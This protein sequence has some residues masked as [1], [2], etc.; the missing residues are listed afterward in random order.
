MNSY[1][2]H[3]VFSQPFSVENLKFDVN[4]IA[5]F[6]YDLK[7]TMNVKVEKS[8][9]GGW[10]SS[11]VDMKSIK[12]IEFIKLLDEIRI[13]INRVSSNIGIFPELDI[14]NLWININQYGNYN[15][16]HQHFGS[17]LSGTF[18]VRTPENCGNINFNNPMGPLMKSYIHPWNF[19][20]NEL[21]DFPWFT[22]GVVFPCKE[23]MMLIFPSWMEHSVDRNS[24]IN[25]DRISISFNTRRK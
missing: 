22:S 8:N 20:E 11:D 13:G 14:S 4:K 1:K 10:Q 18:Y 15:T 12:N 2:I 6:C 7:N 9:A 17:I 25:Q 23:N 21:N 5:D 19:K 24:N 16:P 3:E